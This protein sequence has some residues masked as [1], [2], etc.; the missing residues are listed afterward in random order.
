MTWNLYEDGKYLA[1]KCF[2]NGKSQQDVVE[3]VLDSIEKNKKI[4]FI[5]GMCGT[6]K[7][8]IA[9]NLAKRLGKSSIVV[10]GKNLQAQ[11]KKDYEEK[12]YLKKD[13]GEN[14]KISVITGRKNHK[15]TFLKDNESYL[16]KVKK[17]VNLKLNDI[18]AGKREAAQ[19]QR[20]LDESADNPSIPCKIE[21]KERNSD[22]LRNYLK[23]NNRINAADFSS[24][25][26]IKRMSV[27]PV[28]PYWSP[29]YPDK[30]ELKNLDNATQ[31]SYMGL[32]DTRFIQYK[33][34]PGCPF[35]EQF[36]SYV[37]SD[38]I[39][40]NS[41]KYKLETAL[42]RK[43]LTE[44]EIID[45]CDEFLDSLSNQRSINVDR[46]Q[47]ALVALL[48]SEDVDVNVIKELSEIVSHLKR[49]ERVDRISQT[50]EIL[51]LK[52]TG[53]YD[54]LRMILKA[55]FFEFID[56][57][58]YLMEVLE[59][60]KI[61]SGFIEESFVTVE[62]K[63]NNFIFNL[64]TTNLAK[65]LKEFIEKNK[66]L[67]LMSGT[68]HSKEVLANVFGLDEFDII[69]AEIEKQG[70]SEIV[71]TGLEIDCKYSNF[72]SGKHTREDYLKAFERS[73]EMAKKPVLVHISA[74]QDLPSDEEVER[75]GLNSLIS[76]REL[77]EFQGEDK[78]GNLVRE[79]KEGK[80][81]ILFSTR[82]SR[83]IDF[84][85]EECN[86]I[87]F[88]KYPNPNVQD[89]FWKILMQTRPEYYWL[90]YRDKAKRELEQKLYRGLRFKED[91][92]FVLSP[93]SRVIEFFE[94]K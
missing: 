81:K 22:R 58:N 68:L 41:A 46:M 67:V 8:A 23:Q 57:E 71:K 35:Y 74:F 31:R 6:G 93:D 1:P 60:A 79:F 85:G 45:E 63:E 2:S 9:L 37:D 69:E 5:H 62:R 65:K 52:Q 13:S 16:P 15:C 91:H 78:T 84:P 77:K 56:E 94:K 29:V 43:P 28:C 61:F 86:S 80:R 4:I 34:K 47:T 48:N 53:I 24:V 89:P 20:E 59:T 82:D 66:V 33:R 70:E 75:Y 17:E 12:K 50:K 11:Y 51:P 44:V 76:R 26:D 32:N 21:I 14:L 40:F 64:V 36:D 39:V 42:N 3:E 54:I 83:G 87:V 19:R 49:D 72:S 38:V 55:D 7:S 27:A 25:K 92:V 30:F 88:S 73:V 18:F 90:F 10:P